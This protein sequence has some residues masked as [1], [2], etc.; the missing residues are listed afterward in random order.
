[1]VYVDPITGQQRP[2][3]GAFKP[4]DDGISVYSRDAMRMSKVEPTDLLVRPGSLL[5]SLGVAHIREVDSSIDVVADPWPDG[6]PEPDH[7][8]NASHALIT[9]FKGLTKS[10]RKRVQDRLVRLA[11]FLDEPSS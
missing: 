2:T 5:V 6:I 7:P 11:A 9:G 8:R 1:M 3:S 10:Q 4:D